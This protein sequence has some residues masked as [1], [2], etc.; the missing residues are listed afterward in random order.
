MQSQRTQQK[1]K[2]KVVAEP[3]HGHES[4]EPEP[5]R[6]KPKAQPRKKKI[7]PLKD[8]EEK[9]ARRFRSH[10]PQSFLERLD[11]I[12]VQ[13]MFVV[14]H[15]VQIQSQASADENA[16][17]GVPEFYFTMVGTT[18]NIYKVTIGKVPTCDCP[19]GEKGNQ[20]KHICYVLVNCLKAPQ[21]LQYQLA[22]LSSELRQIYQVYDRSPLRQAQTALENDDGS[23]NDTEDDI[24]KAAEENHKPADGDCPI[25]FMEFKPNEKLVWCKASCGNNVHK[26]C[27]D[28]WA[29]TTR[30]SGVRCVY[31]RAD[32]EVDAAHIPDIKTL[33]NEGPTN[34]EGYRNVASAFGLSGQRGMDLPL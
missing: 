23:H 9:R 2:S 27:F 6:K 34:E 3:S 22:F 14:A 32:W 33:Q 19:D 21:H 25:C 8:K 7:S 31:C 24:C 26:V 11:R 13:R 12:R 5:V 16:N 20:C 1:R 4:P 17:Q 28:Q 29:A 10:A 30:K 15:Q 18:G